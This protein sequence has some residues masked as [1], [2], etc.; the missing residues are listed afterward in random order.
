MAWRGAL[1]LMWTL[2]A[3]LFGPQP[4]APATSPEVALVFVHAGRSLAALA[5][6]YALRRPLG[7]GVRPREAYSVEISKEAPGHGVEPLLDLPVGAA[8]GTLRDDEI[9][10]AVLNDFFA[11]PGAVGVRFDTGPGQPPGTRELRDALEVARAR[12]TWLL[13]G[14]GAPAAAAARALGVPVLE[15]TDVLDAAP[16]P[17]AVASRVRTLIARARATGQAV[18]VAGLDGP[19]LAVIARSLPDFDRAGVSIVPPS[20]LLR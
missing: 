13:D 12:G 20:A 8:G 18:G 2:A 10:Q 1:L 11:A 19:A 15:V 6:V 4:S 5:P 3:G 17:D 7:L 14:P 9:R 16:S